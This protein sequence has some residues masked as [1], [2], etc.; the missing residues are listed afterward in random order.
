MTMKPE[1]DKTVWHEG[2][3][4]AAVIADRCWGISVHLIWPVDRLK[5]AAYIRSD[6]GI[7]YDGMDDEWEGL[8][9][10]FRATDFVICFREME[11]DVVPLLVHEC[12]HVVE[13]ALVA[14]GCLHTGETN[15]AWA[16][17]L[18][19]LVRRLLPLLRERPRSDVFNSPSLPVQ[20]EGESGGC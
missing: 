9:L 5:A 1:L 7:E 20:V 10:G 16:Y 15:E 14:R 12:F 13:S 18:D 3:H 17:L 2:G 19:S 4:Y 6:L 11:G 8:Q